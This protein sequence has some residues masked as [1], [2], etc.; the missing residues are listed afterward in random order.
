MTTTPILPHTINGTHCRVGG[1]GWVELRIY[2]EQYH[3]LQTTRIGLTHRAERG[4]VDPAAMAATLTAAADAENVARLAMVRCYRRV[5]P[6]PIREWQTSH[7]GIGEHALARL[8]GVTG[9]PIHT[10]R[11]EWDG[12][13]TDRTLHVIGEYNRRVSDLW[14]YCGHGDPARARR[15]RGMT[16]ADAA[17]MGSP[18]A[19]MLV[20]LI[21]EACMKQTRSP[22]R[23]VYDTARAK[24]ADR[25]HDTDCP[26]CLKDGVPGGPWRPGHQHAAALRLVGKTILKDLWVAAAR[27]DT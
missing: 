15:H 18:K 9:H 10:T 1:D 13:G 12:T 2:A 20:R 6:Q 8:L 23:D 22:Y 16:A 19:K 26:Q 11:H 25:V 14:S 21:A 17:A 4:G 3:D 24:Y 7:V 5:V 27:E